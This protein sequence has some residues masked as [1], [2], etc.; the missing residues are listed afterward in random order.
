M[1][2]YSGNILPNEGLVD[3]LEEVEIKLD[4]GEGVVE[5][6]LFSGGVLLEG[7]ARELLALDD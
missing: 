4:G 1:S 5:G 3:E 7:A 6:F 2:D